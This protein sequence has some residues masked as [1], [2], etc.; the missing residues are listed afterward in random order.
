MVILALWISQ[1]DFGRAIWLG[2]GM[3]GTQV[4]GAE[5]RTKSRKKFVSSRLVQPLPVLSPTRV[6]TSPQPHN[7]SLSPF[8]LPLSPSP[9]VFRSPSPSPFLS[10]PSLPISHFIIISSFVLCSAPLIFSPHP[11][12][13]IV[14]LVMS[15]L[16]C[17]TLPCPAPNLYPSHPIPFIPSLALFPPLIPCHPLPSPSP[18]HPLILS[19]TSQSFMLVRPVPSR[20][21]S[22]YLFP[23]RLRYGSMC[24]E[25]HF[26]YFLGF[27]LL[28]W[29]RE[30]Y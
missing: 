29:L 4:A 1:C 11:T 24:N 18:Y 16:V 7:S 9:P 21:S 10:S 2:I 28:C 13:A 27:W 8:P 6:P 19:V 26:V 3:D 22:S 23:T 5:M 25:K 20:L 12:T 17:S 14:I 30:G 15:R